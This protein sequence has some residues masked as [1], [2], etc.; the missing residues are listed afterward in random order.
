MVPEKIVQA[1]VK[2][3]NYKLRQQKVQIPLHI[4]N[5]TFHKDNLNDIIQDDELFKKTN[6]VQVKKLNN[7]E[8]KKNK[9]EKKKKE[10]NFF[11]E[12][13]KKANENS[14]QPLKQNKRY[15]PNTTKLK[16]RNTQIIFHL[17]N[18]NNDDNKYNNN[19]K[20]IMEIQQKKS[21]INYLENYLSSLLKERSKLENELE[22]MPKNPRTLTDIKSKNKIK[23][24]ISQNKNEIQNIQK[25]LKKERGY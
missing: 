16:I 9:K 13:S 3:K 15:S 6:T 21:E 19:I 20:T 25:K 17:E 22:E 10:K 18:D 12:E 11:L 2:I 24:K 14:N 7:K 1:K 8:K 5:F 23:D 4:E